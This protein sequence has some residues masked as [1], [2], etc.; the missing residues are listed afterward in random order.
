M[1]GNGKRAGKTRQRRSPQQISGMVVT[2]LMLAVAVPAWAGF[3]GRLPATSGGTD[4]QAFYDDQLDVTW[5]KYGNWAKYQGLSSD[6]R[7]SWLDVTAALAAFEV[8]GVKG[9]RLPNVDRNGDGTY[10]NCWGVTPRDICKDS[11]LGHLFWYGAGDNPD[12]TEGIRPNQAGPFYPDVPSGY[13]WSINPCPHAPTS[14][15]V[16]MGTPF[17]GYAYANS[18]SNSAYTFILYPG[19]VNDALVEI[20]DNGLDDDLDGLVDVADPDCVVPPPETVG[21]LVRCMHSP[22]YPQAGEQ[23]AIRAWALDRDGATV[24]A[25]RVE[26]V[27][28]DLDNVVT[29]SSSQALA[30]HWFTPQGGSFS[31]G[32]RAARGAEVAQSWYAPAPR[33][34]SVDVGALNNPDWKAVPVIYHGPV[35]D[36]LDIVFFHDDDQYTSFRDPQFLTDV[37]DL[38]AEGLWTIPWFVE[39]Q[40]AFNI[41]IA[42]A[43]TADADPKDNGRCKR[44]PPERKNRDYPYRDA[45]GIVHKEGVFSCRDNAGSG[46]MFTIEAER[47][48]GPNGN[49]HRM[50][51]L[52]HEM[53]HRPFGLPDEYCWLDANGVLDCDG[54]YWPS[55]WIPSVGFEPPFPSLF[56]FEQ[57]CRDE[58]AN[59]AYEADDCRVI[60]PRKVLHTLW[61][62]EPNHL[63]VNPRANQVRDLMQQSGA[64]W[65]DGRIVDRYRVGPSELDRMNW[66]VRRCVAGRC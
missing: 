13:Y 29:N 14:C 10:V 45:G 37:H 18:G 11:E 6:G 58:A 52:A 25:D 66:L 60:T 64:E 46:R 62:G 17:L 22:I 28:D 40:W 2:I 26:V 42:T 49:R 16:V 36:K 61:I 3:H 54:G 38:V 57:Q 47:N 9:W 31:Y 32:C 65:I 35:S 30:Q 50:Q 20:C 8:N 53:G 56:A 39:H 55:L 27:L 21:L 48:G 41:W 23:V 4:F 51:V 44:D 19:D 34:R 63:L 15:S 43:D 33:L 7:A 12:G 24:T 59:R 5:Y 1:A